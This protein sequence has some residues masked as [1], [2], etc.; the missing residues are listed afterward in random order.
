MKT[1]ATAFLPRSG[2]SRRRR[3]LRLGIYGG[4]FDPVHH[5]HLLLARDALEQLR[6]D[7]VLFVPC[8]Q[9]PLKTRKPRASDARRLAMLRLALKNHPHFWLTRCEIDRPAPSYSHDTALEIR[10]AF[11]R[12]A[13]FWLIGADQLAAL[14]QW[15]RPDDLRRLVTFVVLPR[16]GAAAP[17]PP[18]TVL[19][20][21]RPRRVDIS[22]TEIRHRVKSRL[23]IDHLVPAPIAAYIKRHGLYLS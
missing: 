20:L 18:G 3:Q 21:P 4:T 2:Q 7:A 14:D 11:P 17:E 6:L 19:S 15:H 8:G 9:S 1:N 16:E 12:A 13:L 5:G 22:A 10:E 23:P